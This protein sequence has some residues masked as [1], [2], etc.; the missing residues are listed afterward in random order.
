MAHAFI[1]KPI[2]GI[3]PK[4]DR[5]TERN[6]KRRS[7]T[8]SCRG[9]FCCRL[10]MTKRNDACKG[11]TKKIPLKVELHDKKQPDNSSRVVDRRSGAPGRIRTCDLPVRSRA[12]YPL[13][14]KRIC[15]FDDVWD[16]LGKN[17]GYTVLSSRLRHSPCLVKTVYRLYELAGKK[18]RANPNFLY[19]A[20]HFPSDIKAQI[21]FEKSTG[22]SMD[23][24]SI[25]SAWV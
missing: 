7:P 16:G 20:G 8:A 25:R 22:S 11:D 18:S 17:G 6:M 14:Y 4:M 21:L 1:A 12:L 5:G 24:P 23:I 3:R 10:S 9:A 13:S 19:R 15:Y 2:G